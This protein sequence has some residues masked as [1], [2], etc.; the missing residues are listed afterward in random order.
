VEKAVTIIRL[1]GGNIA[2]PEETRAMLGLAR[3][4]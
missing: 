2:T 3:R 1:L 4:F